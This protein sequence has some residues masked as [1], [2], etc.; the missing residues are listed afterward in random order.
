[1]L[2]GPDAKARS[3]AKVCIAIVR[4]VISLHRFAGHGIADSN[5]EPSAR[6]ASDATVS[7]ESGAGG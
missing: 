2:C 5:N 7:A 6:S 1:M 4:S 3:Q